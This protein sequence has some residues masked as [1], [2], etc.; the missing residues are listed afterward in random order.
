R[1]EYF[2]RRNDFD[3]RVH[4]LLQLLICVVLQYYS[5][6]I[7]RSAQFVGRIANPT[8]FGCGWMPRYRI[9]V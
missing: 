9:T 3:S 4:L 1:V 8:Y 6:S 5:A 7:A 2:E